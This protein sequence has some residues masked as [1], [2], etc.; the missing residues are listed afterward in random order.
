LLGCWSSI[1]KQDEGGQQLNVNSPKCVKKG[2]V[3]H[4]MLHAVGFA[5]QQSASNRDEYVKIIW[6]NISEGHEHNFNKYN[7][8]VVTD[9]GTTYDYESLMHY[10]GKAFS[11]NGQDT[12]VATKPTQRLGQRNGFTDTDLEKLNKMYSSPCHLNQHNEDSYDFQDIE[13]VTSWFREIYAFV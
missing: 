11:K 13:D 2:V 8:S 6:E 10:S 1:G 7:D 3:M 9:F 12:M 4:E 5:H